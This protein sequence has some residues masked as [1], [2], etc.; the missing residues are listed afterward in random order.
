MNIKIHKFDI[1]VIKYLFTYQI[2]NTDHKLGHKTHHNK[3]Q[4]IKILQ[5]MFSNDDEISVEF[6]NTLLCGK[7]KYLEMNQHNS[8]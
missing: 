4:N 3:I 1:A 8:K 2:S 5:Y 7:S 6:K